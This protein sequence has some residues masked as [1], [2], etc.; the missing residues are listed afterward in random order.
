MSIV[1]GRIKSKRNERIFYKIDKIETLTGGLAHDIGN[2]YK[3][4]N[5]KDE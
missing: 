1:E 5:N 3:K 2:S 4:I